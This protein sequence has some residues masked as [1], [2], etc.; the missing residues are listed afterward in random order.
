[1]KKIS[2]V[3]SISSGIVPVKIIDGEYKFLLLRS[4]KYWDFPKGRIEKNESALEAAIRETEEETTISKK[5]LDFKW[6]LSSTK[7]DLYKKGTKY[8]I[9][10]IAES[11][12]EDISLP[13]S[14][15]LG[16]PEHDEY[17]WVSYKSASGL[18]VKRIKKILDWANDILSE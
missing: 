18:V 8:A 3:T 4:G 9:Y 6:G 14:K 1:M 7:S 2:K 16:K 12:K 10:F 5:D 11:K 17:R 13:I 15:E